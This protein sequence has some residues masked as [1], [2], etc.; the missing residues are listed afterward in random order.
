MHFY[1]LKFDE[2][3]LRLFLMQPLPLLINYTLS[4]ISKIQYLAYYYIKNASCL[5]P[6]YA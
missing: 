4:A 2:P 5:I 3:L 1:L 6:R